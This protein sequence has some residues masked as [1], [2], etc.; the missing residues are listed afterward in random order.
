MP[1]WPITC[2]MDG[3]WTDPSNG[4]EYYWHCEDPGVADIDG[5]RFCLKHAKERQESESESEGGDE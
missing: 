3:Y 2:E 4:N 5:M 1:R